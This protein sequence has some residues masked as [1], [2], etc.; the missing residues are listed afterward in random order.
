MTL[1]VHLS[2]SANDEPNPAFREDPVDMTGT[3]TVT[4]LIIGN[5]YA[6]LRYST[7]KFVPTKGNADTFLESRFDT[8]HIFTALGTTYEYEDPKKISS[9]GSVY[10]RC[11]P[12]PV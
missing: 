7:Y 3:V 11:V 12:M 5:A 4:N 9:K 1:P 10:Y 6:L 8:Q 2:V